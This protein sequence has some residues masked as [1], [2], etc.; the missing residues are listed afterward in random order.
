MRNGWRRKRS[1]EWKLLEIEKLF[2]TFWN[3]E[4]TIHTVAGMQRLCAFSSA[5]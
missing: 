2:L 1:K 3:K 5:G 4:V